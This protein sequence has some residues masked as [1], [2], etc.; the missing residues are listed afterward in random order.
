MIKRLR[1]NFTG[2]VQGIGFRYT[3]RS[4]AKDLQVS[5]WVRNVPDGSV[6]LVAEGEETFLKD[7]LSQIQHELNYARYKESVNWEPATGEF[8]L[9][10][11][12]Y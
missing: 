12:R 4:L 9:F 7:L 10:E 6:E 11:I 5:G 2:N 3:A 1:A 8:S